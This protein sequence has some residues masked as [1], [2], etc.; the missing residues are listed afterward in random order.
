MT[1][2]EDRK[3]ETVKSDEAGVG[4]KEFRV[5]SFSL[6]GKIRDANYLNLNK[7]MRIMRPEKIKNGSY[8][9]LESTNNL[10]GRL[11][12]LAK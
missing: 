6:V 11:D 3:R 2:H 8:L 9:L 4:E 5:D 10:Q 12:K 7:K 1:F